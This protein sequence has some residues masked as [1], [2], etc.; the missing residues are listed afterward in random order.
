MGMT[1][2]T[3]DYLLRLALEDRKAR[4]EFNAAL[5]GGPI[6]PKRTL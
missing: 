2:A 4:L 5:K 6:E 1:P 3:L